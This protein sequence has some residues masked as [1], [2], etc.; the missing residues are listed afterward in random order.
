MAPRTE[1]RG[2]GGAARGLRRQ[3]ENNA[4][5]LA[6]FGGIFALLLVF[7]L[8][9]NLLFEESLRERLEQAEEK[10]LYRI[11]SEYG[12]EGFVVITFPE[13]LR[14]VETGEGVQR[15]RICE[16]SS[17]FVQYARRVYSKDRKQLVFALL[18]GSVSTMAEARGCIRQLMPN[19]PLNIGWIMAD[20]ELLK[21]VSLDDIP[22]YIRDFA[23]P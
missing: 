22:P 6:L 11:Q 7:L 21:S 12:G 8:L 3:E 1:S 13:T 20:N 19:R 18:E 23:E 10:G 14:I 9:V 15:G 16:E 4:P 5:L 17:V 2:P